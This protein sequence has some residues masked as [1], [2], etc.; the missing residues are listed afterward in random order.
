M[1][2]RIVITPGEP[3]G[4]GPDLCVQIAQQSFPCEIVLVC[5]PELLRARAQ[6][7]GL[8]LQVEIFDP[9]KTAAVVAGTIKVVPA[10]LHRPVS[11]GKLDSANAAYVLDTLRIAVAGCMSGTFAALV[12]GPVHKGI[13]NDAGIAF[14]GHTEFLAELTHAPQ[15]VMMLTAPGLRV[16]L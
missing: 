4:I 9:Q 3:A 6:K 14:S 1:L 11:C 15:P 12:T 8:P 5:D 10:K 7:L 16:A 13:I 2:P